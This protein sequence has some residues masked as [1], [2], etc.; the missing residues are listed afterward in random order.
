MVEESQT[1]V[2]VVH[3]EEGPV[4]DT[5][6]YDKFKSNF[7]LQTLQVSTNRLKLDFPSFDLSKSAIFTQRSFN[8]I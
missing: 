5:E 4:A 8:L 3:D 7:V 2:Q 1:P 6:R